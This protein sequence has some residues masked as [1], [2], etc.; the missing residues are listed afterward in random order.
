MEYDNRGVQVALAPWKMT[1]EIET[2]GGVTIE[3]VSRASSSSSV[4][5]FSYLRLAFDFHQVEIDRATKHKH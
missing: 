5:S 1:K 2:W 4:T 3:G